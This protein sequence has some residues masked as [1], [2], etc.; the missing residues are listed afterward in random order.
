MKQILFISFLLFSSL[1]SFSQDSYI[2]LD[3]KTVNGTVENYKEWSKNPTTVLF[4]D[5]VNDSE[6]ILT[7]ENC[8]SFTVGSDYFISYSGTRILNSDDILSQ[9]LKSDQMVKDSI[10]VF[11][12]RIYQFN[13]YALYKLYDNKRINYYVSDHINIKEL[14]FY[15]TI[16]DNT[17]APFNGYKNYLMQHFSSKGIKGLEWK[18]NNLNYKENDL[19][20]FF[21]FVFRDKSHSSENLRNK[22][23]SEILLGAGSTNLLQK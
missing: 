13:N 14:E 8:K 22:Y 21:A 2:T 6:I 16:K 9:G 17:I 20:N 15:E 5:N 12:R 4:K 1:F 7:I 11:L 10:H 19:L 18:I 3:G 23:A